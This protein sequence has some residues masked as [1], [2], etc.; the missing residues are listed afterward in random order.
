MKTLETWIVTFANTDSGSY[1]IVGVCRAA[2][3]SRTG[4][5]IG[6]YRV[7]VEAGGSAEAKAAARVIVAEREAR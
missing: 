5:P 6:W 2:T 7:R 4:V 1:I 3:D